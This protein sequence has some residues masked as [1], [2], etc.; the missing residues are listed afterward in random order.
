MVERGAMRAAIHDWLY[1]RVG[2][3]EHL[4]EF[5]G[6]SGRRFIV[7]DHHLPIGKRLCKHAFNSTAQHRQTSV[8]RYSNGDE[9]H[10]S[11]GLRNM[12]GSICRIAEI[13]ILDSPD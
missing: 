13:R 2:S 3:G 10:L 4:K 12:T 6:L 5:P 9:G 8:S 11:Y 1:A 7:A